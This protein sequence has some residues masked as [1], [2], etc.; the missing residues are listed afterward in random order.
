MRVAVFVAALV[1]ASPAAAAKTPLPGIRTPSGNISCFF[2]PGPPAVLQCQIKQ[3]SYAK[4]LVAYCGQPK[5]GVDWG[6]FSLG[7]TRKGAITCT[8]GVL[9]NPD[10][11]RLAFL[12]LPYGQTWRQGVFTCASAVT[13]LTCRNR[14]G[15][16]LFISR[17]S[18]RAW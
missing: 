2:V 13:G 9:Y 11:Q 15:H 6:G 5:I 10:T 14:T 16:G 4:K 7:A 18:W 8:G 1:L 3:A 17:E 12:T